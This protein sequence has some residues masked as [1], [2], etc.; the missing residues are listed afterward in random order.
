MNSYAKR[1]AVLIPQYNELSNG[2]FIGRLSYFNELAKL[3]NEILD[4]IIINDGS[5]DNSLT[6]IEEFIKNNSTSFSVA[7]VTPNAN[8][9]GALYLAILNIN[10]DY[11]LFSDFDTDL[12]NLEC[13]P[14][15]LKRLDD[16]ATMMG[17]YFRMIPMDGTPIIVRYQK[18]EY[19]VARIWYK[20]ISMDRSVAVMPGAGSLYKCGIL[21]RILKNHS[22]RRNG[23]D[24]ETTIIGIKF[25]YEVFYQKNILAITRTPDTLKKL[26]LQRARWALGYLET[27]SKEK[28]LY[29]EQIVSFKKLGQRSFFDF[30]SNILLL[31]LPLLVI[32]VA[33]FSLKTSLLIIFLCYISKLVWIRFILQK[34]KSEVHEIN[35]YYLELVLYPLL[36]VITELPAWT[37]AISKFL[38]LGNKRRS[39]KKFN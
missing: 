24:R 32:V 5:T 6:I 28:G 37:K 3:Y 22:G 25:G 12:A 14:E 2:N 16:S 15:T 8:K 36:K 17:C 9:V 1:V 13:L 31:I 7:S 21:R 30:L 39:M 27:F 20:Y 10:Y 38:T 26:I 19:A 34:E 18:L 33:F 11:I 23:E 4:V 29:V 35:S